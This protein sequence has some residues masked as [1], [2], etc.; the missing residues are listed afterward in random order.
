MILEYYREDH[1]NAYRIL[2][3][4]TESYKIVLDPIG[5]VWD[6]RPA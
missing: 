4:P 6:V 1:L 2:Q 5:R 3:Y